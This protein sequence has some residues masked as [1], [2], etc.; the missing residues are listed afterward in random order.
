[1]KISA[2]AYVFTAMNSDM[3]NRK[4]LRGWLA[5]PG[6]GRLFLDITVSD[7]NKPKQYSIPFCSIS[8]LVATL[9]SVRN[10]TADF[11]KF[12][13][14]NGNHDLVSR[15]MAKRRCLKIKIDDCN[16]EFD[17]MRYVQYLGKSAGLCGFG[18]TSTGKLTLVD[19][20]S[21][22]KYQLMYFD[23]FFAAGVLLAKM[24]SKEIVTRIPNIMDA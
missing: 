21:S 6:C 23:D 24:C 7:V 2:M 17:P 10:D 15:K 18:S 9:H 19:Y 14:L 5:Y 13:V 4:K 12:M 16:P 22:Y 1:M 8:Q 11:S 3:D 20:D